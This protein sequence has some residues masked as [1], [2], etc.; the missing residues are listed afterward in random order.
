VDCGFSTAAPDWREDRIFKP[1]VLRALHRRLFGRHHARTL[2]GKRST[3]ADPRRRLVIEVGNA[4]WLP[5]GA[6]SL[7]VGI[8]SLASWILC[9]RHN[10]AL[11]RLDAVGTRFY[12]LF[13]N[14]QRDLSY[15]E[16][17]GPFPNTVTLVN[18]ADIE[19]WMLKVLWGAIEAGTIRIR[20]DKAYRFR[21]GV[22]RNSWPKYSGGVRHGHVRG[23]YTR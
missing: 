6:D 8:N 22:S 1:P 23:V 18:G 13:R 14:D 20:G 4:A 12:E 21:L 17:V 19:R 11:S 2:D 15:H 9:R 3:Q 5:S 7:P 10:H 16:G